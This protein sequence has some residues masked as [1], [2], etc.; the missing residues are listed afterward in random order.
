MPLGAILIRKAW[1]NTGNEI[2]PEHATA[3]DMSPPGL[4]PELLR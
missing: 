4:E 1:S 2:L 3:I